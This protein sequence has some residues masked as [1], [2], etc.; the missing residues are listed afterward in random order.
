MPGI[1]RR[2]WLLAA[3]LLWPLLAWS[4]TAPD[5]VHAA[6]AKP[7]GKY[8]SDTDAV[9]LLDDGTA[10]VTA[11]GEMEFAQ[12]RVVRI[13]RPEGRREGK[14]SV[15]L[16]AGDKLLGI[17]A[18][19]I[20]RDGREYE[21]KDKE[22]IEVSPFHEVLYTDIKY[23]ATEAPAANPGSVIAL[24]YTVRRHTFVDQVHWFFQEDIPVSEARYTLQ[25]PAGWEYKAS[26]ANQPALQ[27]AQLG[28]NRWQW[29]CT[30]LPGISEERRRPA[31]EAL[32]GHME[33]AFYPPAGS[34][35]FGTWQTIGDWY[36]HLT[37]GR[38]SN[39]PEIAAK[40]QQLTASAKTFDEKIKALAGFMQAE[41][42]YV[43]IAI[44]IGGY[45][46]H[47]APDVFH[48]R[49]GDCKD[50][51]TLLSAM[52][53][54]AGINSDYVLV[55]TERGVVKPDVPSTLFNHAI[56]GIELPDDVLAGKYRSVTTT[57][58]GKRYLIFDPTDEYTPIGDLRTALQGSYALLVDKAGGELIRLPILPADTNRFDREGKFALQAD[59]SL[60]GT[61]IERRTGDHATGERMWMTQANEAERM[62]YVDHYLELSLKNVTVQNAKFGDASAK[63]AELVQ[64][65][66]ISVQN[67]AQHSGPLLLV[68]P[69]VVGDKAQSFDWAKR[70]YPVELSG[71]TIEKDVYEIQLPPGF[72]VDDLPEPLHIDVGFAKYSSK[73]EAAGSTLRYSRE[74][75]ISDPNVG[76]DR[77]PDLRKFESVIA[78]DEYANAVLKKQP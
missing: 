14:L 60:T 55:D 9:V 18:W 64:E 37:E 30:E 38:R 33:L 16:N 45:Q 5:W 17:H 11:P 72:V 73:V 23:R 27:P 19:S 25:L 51:A 15:Y 7:A 40:V 76:P 50:K 78:E 39:S 36:Y 4:F 31:Q 48:S 12:R 56:L 47:A 69:R 34:T 13:L 61:L 6:A 41:V 26:W 70:K 28:P 54:D 57:K 46:P 22:F 2:W 8:P 66:K 68:R 58:A 49:Y 59:G 65:Y 63:G 29:T 62:K 53:A 52:L 10:N 1:K 42:R 67:Y 74:Y 3:G 71:A 44:G 32:A 24:E 75:V 35:T 43:A 21:V 20:D 77:L